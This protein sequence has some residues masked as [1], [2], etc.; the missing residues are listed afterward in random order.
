MNDHG[1]KL[2][3]AV[4]AAVATVSLPVVAQQ[5]ANPGFA[6]VGRGAPLAATLPPFVPSALMAAPPGPE[7]VQQLMESAARCPFVGPINLGPPQPPAGAPPPPGGAQLPPPR[8]GSAGNGDG[9]V[10]IVP[11]A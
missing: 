10:G 7:Q 11:R 6:S 2:V 8:F 9:P 1:C 5:V 3:T 4:L